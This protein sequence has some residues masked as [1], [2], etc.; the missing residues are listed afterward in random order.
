MREWLAVSILLAL[1]FYLLVFQD[2]SSA[3]LNWLWGLFFK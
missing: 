3:A 1:I 2:Q